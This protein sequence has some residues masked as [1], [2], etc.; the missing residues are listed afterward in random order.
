MTEDQKAMSLILDVLGASRDVPRTWGWISDELKLAGRRND[1]PE[2]LDAM[3]EA[4]LVK[5]VPDKLMGSRWLITEE[6]LQARQ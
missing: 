4:G 1:A 2:L 3:S 6:G 5:K